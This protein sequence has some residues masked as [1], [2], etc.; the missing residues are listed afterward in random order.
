LGLNLITK[1]GDALISGVVSFTP[2]QPGGGRNVT[3]GPPEK[4]GRFTLKPAVTGREG[5]KVTGLRAD[6][7]IIGK[8]RRAPRVTGAGFMKSQT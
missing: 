2:I 5:R 1:P 6:V 7:K 8:I 4:S 3:G